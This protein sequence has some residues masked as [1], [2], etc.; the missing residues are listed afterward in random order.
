METRTTRIR[1][2][3][4]DRLNGYARVY[5]TEL[6]DRKRVAHGRGPT[7][8]VSVQSAQRNWDAKYRDPYDSR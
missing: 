8:E 5:E 3:W 7:C 4:F 6:T 1:R 2:N